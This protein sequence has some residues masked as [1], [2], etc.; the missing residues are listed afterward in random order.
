MLKKYKTTVKYKRNIKKK[1]MLEYSKF[2]KNEDRNTV[3][4]QVKNRINLKR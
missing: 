4:F 2:I 3:W 1:T